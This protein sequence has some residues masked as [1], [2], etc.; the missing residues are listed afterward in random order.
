MAKL[1]QAVVHGA[2]LLQVQGNFDACLRVA[3]ELADNYPVELVNSVNPVR[4]E[5]TEHVEALVVSAG[6][7]EQRLEVEGVFIEM[8]SISADE[9]AM[10]LVEVNEKGEIVVDKSGQTSTP[11][12]YAAG[13]VTDEFGKQIITAAG[14]GARAAM[15]VGRDL[16][17]R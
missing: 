1:A 15:A 14:Q 3:R 6:G 11:G 7:E 12:V 17:R 10:G 5:G 13:D 2:Q 8:G 9:F 16:K 4:I